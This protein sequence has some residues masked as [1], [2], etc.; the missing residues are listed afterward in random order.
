MRLSNKILFICS[1]CTLILITKKKTCGCF[2]ILSMVKL[3]LYVCC[4]WLIK[5]QFLIILSCFY[6]YSSVIPLG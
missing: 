4:D 3:V 2:I 6:I 1:S 5:G